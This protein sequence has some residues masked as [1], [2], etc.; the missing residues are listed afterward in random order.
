MLVDLAKR[1]VLGGMLLATTSWFT[2]AHDIYRSLVDS[3]GESCCNQRDCRPARYRVTAAGVEMLVDGSWLVVPEDT[4]Q[5]R[6]LEG[7][8]GETA[9][10]HW[11]SRTEL[12]RQRHPFN[13]PGVERH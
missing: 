8:T 5:Y 11:F 1:L 13:E 12:Y 4:I 10:G 6:A 9:G 2:Q 3:S 7:D